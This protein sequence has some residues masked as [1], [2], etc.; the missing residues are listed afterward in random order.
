MPT[1]TPSGRTRL[2]TLGDVPDVPADLLNLA[3]DLETLIDA[4]HPSKWIKHGRV[5]RPIESNGFLRITAAEC[6]FS[7][8]APARLLVDGIDERFYPGWTGEVDGAGALVKV[9]TLNAVRYTSGQ[10]VAVNFAAF[11]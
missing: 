9:W 2:P 10:T 6:F 11:R 4:G 7:G 1:T 8:A 5:D 3:Y